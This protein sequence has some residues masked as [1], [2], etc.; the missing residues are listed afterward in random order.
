[1]FVIFVFQLEYRMPFEV[2]RYRTLQAT[3]WNYAHDR[4]HENVFLGAVSIQ[5]ENIFSGV[6]SGVKVVKWYNL[7]NFDRI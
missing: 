5:L 6:S 2:V 7:S 4:L 3:V 1:M